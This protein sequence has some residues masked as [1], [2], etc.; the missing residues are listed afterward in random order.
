MV[1]VAVGIVHPKVEGK[2]QYHNQKRVVD[3]ELPLFPFD[4]QFG[5]E[6]EIVGIESHHL[7]QWSHADGQRQGQVVAVVMA[8]EREWCEI[9]QR[10]CRHVYQYQVF[11]PVHTHITY[12]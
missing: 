4:I 9:H 7:Q 11:V 1:E 3:P 6:S 10:P 8:E 2:A 12:D 5:D